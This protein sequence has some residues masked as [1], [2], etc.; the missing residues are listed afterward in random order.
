M[1]VAQP[2]TGWVQPTLAERQAC[3]KRSGAAPRLA[4][5]V[6]PTWLTI[7]FLKLT[8][9][10]SFHTL[11]AKPCVQAQVRVC[12]CVLVAPQHPPCHWFP[13]TGYIAAC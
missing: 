12:S 4:A 5:G 1:A 2:G 8:S 6:I 9:S 11:Q 10:T 3:R 7:G 13:S